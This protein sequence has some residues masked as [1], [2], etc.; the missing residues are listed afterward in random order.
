MRSSLTLIRTERR[1]E[2]YWK[3]DMST[4]ETSTAAAGGEARLSET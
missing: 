2:G 3:S 4:L 1:G